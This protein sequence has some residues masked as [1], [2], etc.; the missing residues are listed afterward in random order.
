MVLETHEK[1]FLIPA[2]IW[3]PWFS[4]F[5]S[6]SGFD[7]IEECFG[8]Y[9][10]EIFALETGL[11]SDPPMNWMWSE[12]DRF[13]LVSNSDAHSG[14]KLG[15]EA[16]LFKG[17]VSYDT[18]YNALKFR[19]GDFLGTI[20]FFPE[21]GKYHLDGHRKCG[22]VLEPEKAIEFNNIC[23]V[24]KQPLTIGVMHRILSL[25]DRKKPQKPKGSPDFHSLIPLT[26]II[27]EILKRGPKT[28]AV[29]RVYKSLIKEFRS[30]IQILMQVPV[31]ELKKNSLLDWQWVLI[32]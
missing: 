32:K 24:C 5:G 28:K 21:E 23:P 6:R 22:I 4:L 26:E 2:H 20:E 16:N 12:L 19:T 7:S 10:S 29:Y 30:E 31:E 25:A 14:E 8:S 1:A 17:D 15:R 11:S 27:S 13:Y 18:I 9:T 3:T